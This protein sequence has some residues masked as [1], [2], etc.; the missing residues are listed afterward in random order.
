MAI[1]E[2]KIKSVAY[3]AFRKMLEQD[4]IFG[5]RPSTYWIEAI[6]E[7]DFKPKLEKELSEYF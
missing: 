3:I 1:N 7:K 6:W 5:I 4:G 2:E